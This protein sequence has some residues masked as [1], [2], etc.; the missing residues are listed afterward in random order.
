[1]HR[2]RAAFIALVQA[3]A[4]FQRIISIAVFVFVWMSHFVLRPLR[5]WG[6]ILA[7]HVP[8]DAVIEIRLRDRKQPRRALQNISCCIV[9][10]KD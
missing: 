10:A 9:V 1:M 5:A 8:P 2:S 7:A 6:D 4:A 3:A